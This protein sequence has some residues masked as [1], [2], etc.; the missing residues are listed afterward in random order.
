MKARGQDCAAYISEMIEELAKLAREDGRATLGYLLEIAALEA[1]A[2]TK[3]GT[4]KQVSKEQHDVVRLQ[5]RR[6]G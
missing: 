1:Q 3:N 4:P 5:S 6:V 2:G